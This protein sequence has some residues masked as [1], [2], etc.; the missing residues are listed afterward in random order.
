MTGNVSVVFNSQA[1]LKYVSG[2]IQ[3]RQTLAKPFFLL[4][5]TQI[6]L[7]KGPSYRAAKLTSM[8]QLYSA[9]HKAMTGEQL[10]SKSTDVT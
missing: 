9:K 1:C 5:N 10:L 3:T 2:E 4:Q 8:I 7:E 6:S